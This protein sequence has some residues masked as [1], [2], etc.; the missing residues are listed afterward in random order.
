MHKTFAD[1]AKFTELE[2]QQLQAHTLKSIFAVNVMPLLSAS[3]KEEPRHDALDSFRDGILSATDDILK[4]AMLQGYTTELQGRMEIAQSDNSEIE[5]EFSIDADDRSA[6]YNFP[7]LGH[8]LMD[9]VIHLADNLIYDMRTLLTGPDRGTFHVEQLPE[10]INQKQNEYAKSVSS[11]L[12]TVY[13]VGARVARD[14]VKGA[15]N[16]G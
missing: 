7:I 12:A 2:I 10:K 15:I 9:M 13:L 11:Q 16:A 1:L 4:N 5:I 14:H 3:L 6:L 8:N